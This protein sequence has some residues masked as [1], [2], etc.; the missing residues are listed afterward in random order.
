[1]RIL[2]SVHGA[3]RRDSSVT[4]RVHSLRARERERGGGGL[5]GRSGESEHAIHV[6]A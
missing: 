1:M 6:D 3:N 2:V 5:E 4:L